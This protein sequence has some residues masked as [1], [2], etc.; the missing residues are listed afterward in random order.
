[1]ATRRHSLGWGRGA[2]AHRDLLEHMGAH[3]LKNTQEFREV[4]RQLHGGTG[5]S[6]G[7][8]ET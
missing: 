8:P 5:S 2:Q 3:I 4:L 7:R 1:M 6:T